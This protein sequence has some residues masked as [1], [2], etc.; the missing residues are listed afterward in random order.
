MTIDDIFDIHI[1]S[2]VDDEN[3]DKKLCKTSLDST[4]T[5]QITIRIEFC[6]PAHITQEITEPDILVIRIKLPGLLI[7]AESF[8]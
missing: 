1:K 7:D 6:E 8:D 5:M 4:D 3:L 2:T